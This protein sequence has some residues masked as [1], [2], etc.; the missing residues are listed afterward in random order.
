MYGVS[1]CVYYT[2]LKN[3]N[4][5]KRKNN[6][7]L[8]VEKTFCVLDVYVFN[9]LFTF[10]FFDITRLNLL[11]LWFIMLFMYVNFWEISIYCFII[12]VRE[13]N[14]MYIMILNDGW[15][16]EYFTYGKTSLNFIW[17]TFYF[18]GAL[19]R[20]KEKSNGFVKVIY[21]VW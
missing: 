17:G 13:N 20:M 2:S 21:T 14:I 18:A 8:C 11:S 12:L 5:V 10:F 1:R 16:W 7:K 15:T 3:E 19:Q 6:L 4:W 9:T